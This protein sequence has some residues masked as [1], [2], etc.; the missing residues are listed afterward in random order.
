V[1]FQTRNQQS[2]VSEPAN[3]PSTGMTFTVLS[4]EDEH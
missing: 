3:A 1:R 4:L 2:S